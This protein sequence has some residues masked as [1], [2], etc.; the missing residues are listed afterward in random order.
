MKKTVFWVLLIIAAVLVKLRFPGPFDEMAAAAI[1][2][3]DLIIFLSS[4]A[5]TAKDAVGQLATD[6]TTPDS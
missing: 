6:S 5:Q 2:V 4:K 1:G 3:V